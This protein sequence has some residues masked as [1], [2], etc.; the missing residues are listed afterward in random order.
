MNNFAETLRDM[1]ELEGAR[2]IHEQV[3]EIRR[4][5]LGAKHPDTSTSAWNLLIILIKM[6][7]VDESKKILKNDLV[8]LLDRDPESLGADQRKIREMIIRILPGADQPE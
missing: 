3:M 2:K 6:G 5:V 1:G 7:D 4:R 8:W